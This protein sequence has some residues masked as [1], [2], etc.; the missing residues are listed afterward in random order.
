MYPI[1]RI[2]DLLEQLK[3]EMFF[4][5]TYLKYGYHQVPIKP[6]DVWNTTFKFK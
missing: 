4:N 5:K 1:P 2:D 6:T 3:G